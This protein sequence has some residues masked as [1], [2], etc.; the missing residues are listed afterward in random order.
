[1][2]NDES[3]QSCHR[4]WLDFIHRSSFIVGASRFCE[5]SL[6]SQGYLGQQGQVATRQDG[7]VAGVGALDVEDVLAGL[8]RG[9][10]GAGEGD[11]EDAVGG[12]GDGDAG[13]GGLGQDGGGV[14][15]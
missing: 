12:V 15:V 5:A 8:Q 2:M 10:V 7:T 11:L 1:M 4:L 9:G 13:A 3:E 14:A 6:T